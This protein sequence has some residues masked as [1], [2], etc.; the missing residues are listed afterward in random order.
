MLCHDKH[1]LKKLLNYL[2]IIS[3][4]KK[5]WSAVIN[6][7]SIKEGEVCNDV[8]Q[9]CFSSCFRHK[10]YVQGNFNH[11]SLFARGFIF[12][13]VKVI[14]SF[15]SNKRYPNRYF[16]SFFYEILLQMSFFNL[17]FNIENGKMLIADIGN[18]TP[19]TIDEYKFLN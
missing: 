15:T 4:R 18:L 2:I 19:I 12:I 10:N 8:S 1:N 11:K 14:T 7:Q 3:G 16:S 13:T 5:L 9:A 17:G 6:P